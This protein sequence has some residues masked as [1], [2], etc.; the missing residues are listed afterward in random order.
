MPDTMT[1]LRVVYGE[2]QLGLHGAG[3]DYLFDYGQGPISLVIN[4]KEWL[5]RAPQPA[6]WRATTDNDR[7]NG[8][9]RSAA[10]WIGADLFSHVVAMSIT[11][12]GQ[13]VPQPLAPANNDF[14]PG[15]TADTV[16]V[17]YTYETPT[18]P[19]AKVIVRYTV[20]AGGALTVRVRYLGTAGLPQLPAFGLR[21]VMPTPT[22]RFD[23]AGLPGETYPDR[24]SGSKQVCTVQG[25]PVTPYLVP[26]ECGMHMSC[27]WVRLTRETTLN[28]ADHADTPYT[29]TVR[30]A[31]GPF[32]FSC[33]P[34]L[35]SELENATHLEELPPVRRTVFTVYGA[36]RGVG[37]IDSWGAPVQP[38]YTI[39]SDQ[40]CEFAFVINP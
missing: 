18:N 39:P 30:G 9:S 25:M 21:L 38:A 31:D 8:F 22:T 27:D 12:D 26:Q 20:A 11:A 29:L 34:Y 4:G 35:P 3:F 10:Q 14:G 6:F 5:Y 36:V 32:A 19:V 28:N 37:G 40:D 17:S 7:G 33:L 24:C 15:A 23:Y 13:T 2:E 16:G 1:K